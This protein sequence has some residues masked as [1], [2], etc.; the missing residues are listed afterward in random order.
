MVVLVMKLVCYNR[1]KE[2]IVPPDGLSGLCSNCAIWWANKIQKNRTADNRT[3]YQSV[4]I[5]MLI[6]S[7]HSDSLDNTFKWK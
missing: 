7:E 2:S 6:N 5:S 3:I 1:Q 4:F